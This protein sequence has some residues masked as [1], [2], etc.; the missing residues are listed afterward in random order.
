MTV[1]LLVPGTVP[2][3]DWRAIHRGAAVRVDPASAPHIAESAAAVGR[4]LAHGDPVYGINTGFGK[5]ASVRIDAAADRKSVVEGKGVSVRC[6]LGG[7]L[8]MKKKQ[9]QHEKS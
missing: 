2:L 6:D 1:I 9:K 4:I 8:I 7:R 5:L 3:A